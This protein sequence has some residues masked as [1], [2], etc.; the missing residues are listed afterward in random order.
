MLG[1]LRITGA[2]QLD[3]IDATLGALPDTLPVSVVYRTRWW[4]GIVAPRG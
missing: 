2:F 4:V 1:G 3:N